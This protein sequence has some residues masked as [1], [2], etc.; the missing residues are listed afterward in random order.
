MWRDRAAVELTLAVQ[1]SFDLAGV[2]MADHHGESQRFLRHLER[3]EA[4][5][6]S[7]PVDWSWIV[8][9]I[10]GGSR[11]CSTATTT[12]RPTPGP[13]FR[14]DPQQAARGQGCLL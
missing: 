7:C 13:M 11:R 8:P 6:R 2:S 14:L 3:E 4:A 1:H 10:S 12:S 5:G 9:P